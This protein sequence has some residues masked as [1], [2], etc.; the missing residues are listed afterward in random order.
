VAPEVTNIHYKKSPGTR[1]RSKFFSERVINEWDELSVSAD[2]ST[3]TRFK[4]SVLNVDFSDYLVCSLLLYIFLHFMCVFYCTSLRV[5]LH[6]LPCCPVT[7]I[8]VHVTVC[9]CL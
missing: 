9:T 3:V 8:C 1:I 4:G 7:R 5:Q 6:Y 2:F